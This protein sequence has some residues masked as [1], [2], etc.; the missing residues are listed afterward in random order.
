MGL[1]DLGRD[2]K[3]SQRP[4]DIIYVIDTSG[5][6]DGAKIQSVNNAM[7]ELETLLRDEARKNP[8][9]QVNIRILTFGDAQVHWH[10]KERTDVEKYRYN[11]IN[12]VNGSTPLG[13]A[14]GVLCDILGSDKMP[15][16]GLKPIIVLLSDGQP[17][18][19]WEPNLDRLL[20]LPWG[21][22]AIKVAI[23]IG[24]DADRDVLARFTTDPDLVLNANSATALQNFIK[25]TSTLVT[26]SSQRAS[27]RD[28][29]GNLQ[30]RKVNVPSM[31]PAYD[32]AVDDC[33]VDDRRWNK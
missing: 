27:Q 31:L 18:D 1:R 24:K 26:H 17:N 8:A 5:S 19:T 32:P 6:M 9:A 29:H 3:I 4:L 25:W 21:K 2:V 28:S 16:R 7:H 33:F 13:G 22:H 10:I 15:S 30:P 20:S 12:Y 11:D 23:A 14:L